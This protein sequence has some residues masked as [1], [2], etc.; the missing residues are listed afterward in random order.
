M[1]AGTV[2]LAAGAIAQWVWLMVL[3]LADV[4]DPAV[5]GM[6]LVV[7]TVTAVASV[8]FAVVTVRQGDD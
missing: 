4:A 8:L 7:A 3:M 5:S 2:I 6:W 1:R